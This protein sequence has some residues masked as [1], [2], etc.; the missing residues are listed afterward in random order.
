MLDAITQ[1]YVDGMRVCF[2]TGLEGDPGSY[3]H[4]AVA[5]AHFPGDNIFQLRSRLPEVVGDCDWL[6]L[7]E[8]HNAIGPDWIQGVFQAIASAKPDTRILIGQATNKETTS[9]WSWASFLTSSGFHWYPMADRPVLPTLYNCAVRRELLGTERWNT[10]EYEYN[11]LGELALKA[12]AAPTMELDHQQNHTMFSALA[13]HWHNG[14]VAGA[15]L[16][17][18]KL[19]GQNARYYTHAKNVLTLR[20]PALKDILQTHPKR[21]MFPKNT[22]AMVRLLVFTHTVAT[23]WGGWFGGGRSFWYLE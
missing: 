4:P 10:G 6:I 11:I 20:W 7:L 17:D 13:H 1:Q 23:L 15:L 16:A 12:Q 8:D 18:N 2:L 14:R 21:D 19:P 9:N 5:I 22:V 3:P